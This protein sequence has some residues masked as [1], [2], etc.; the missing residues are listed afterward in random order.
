MHRAVPGLRKPLWNIPPSHTLLSPHLLGLPRGHFSRDVVPGSTKRNDYQTA[1]AGRRFP[2]ASPGCGLR[3]TG[4]HAFFHWAA[5]A[6]WLWNLTGSPTSTHCLL[7]WEPLEVRECWTAFQPQ[8]KGRLCTRTTYPPWIAA[9]RLALQARWRACS[10]PRTDGRQAWQSLLSWCCWFMPTTPLP[11]WTT[12]LLSHCPAPAQWPESVL[13]LSGNIIT[14]FSANGLF[15]MI[16]SPSF[17]QSRL[18]LCKI[19][20]IWNVSESCYS[21]GE[22]RSC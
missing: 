3:G 17:L 4:H 19:D 13:V 21:F 18:H 9:E 2:L 1:N 20:I 11:P 10:A 16:M 22:Q 14:T 15:Y 8:D 7:M 12:V 6:F 5:T